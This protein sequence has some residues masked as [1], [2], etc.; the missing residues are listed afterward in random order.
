MSV[1]FGHVPE[2]AVNLFKG[3]PSQLEIGA[4]RPLESE[5]WIVR[6][7]NI[8]GDSLKKFFYCLFYSVIILVQVFQEFYLLRSW[9]GADM[10]FIYILNLHALADGP[11]ESVLLVG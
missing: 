5:I 10:M 11:I 2:A 3:G 6:P 1:Y 4:I 7:L 8:Q 9:L